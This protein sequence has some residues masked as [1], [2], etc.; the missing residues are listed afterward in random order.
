MYN[1]SNNCKPS[2]HTVHRHQHQHPNVDRS[3][4]PQMMTVDAPPLSPSPLMPT[5]QHDVHPQY[6]AWGLG[7]L[8]MPELNH[9]GHA[10]GHSHDSYWHNATAGE[11]DHGR[12]V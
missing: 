7:R 4:S 6:L 1:N 3:A 12:T 5:R 2:V 10:D 8:G 11:Y 9:R